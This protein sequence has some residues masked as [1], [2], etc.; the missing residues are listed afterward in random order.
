DRSTM[1]LDIDN[2]EGAAGAYSIA[3]HADGPVSVG[4][5]A[6]K[7]VQL[8]GGQRNR[9]ALPLIARSAG[10]STV[11]V[12]IKGPGGFA[13][14]RSYALNVA[15]ATQVLTRRTV[16]SLNKDESL[17]LSRDLFADLVPGTG[18]VALSV[19]VSTALDAATLLKA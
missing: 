1:N 7:S 10:P 2:V 18:S 16:E 4:E 17:T 6:A 14:E 11:S 13:L 12:E 3:V 19:G 9:V 5:G 8:R 15:P